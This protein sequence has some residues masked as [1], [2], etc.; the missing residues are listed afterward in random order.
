M[1]STIPVKNLSNLDNVHP[2][3]VLSKVKRYQPHFTTPPPSDSQKNPTLFPTFVQPY[4]EPRRNSG[5]TS[6]F[7]SHYGKFGLP[8][9]YPQKTQDV[10][11]PES[12]LLRHSFQ[13]LVRIVSNLIGIKFYFFSLERLFNKMP[14]LESVR[15]RPSNN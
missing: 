6:F 13:R 12:E 3:E 15:L 2:R 5:F 10:R 11:L 1:S 4:P 7:Q 8:L 14:I 9:H